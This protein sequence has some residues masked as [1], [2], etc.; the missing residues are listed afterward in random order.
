MEDLINDRQDDV[1]L[2]AKYCD[3]NPEFENGNNLDFLKKNILVIGTKDNT[4]F[5]WFVEKNEDYINDDFLLKCLLITYR[6]KS[7]EM[8]LNQKKIIEHV[9]SIKEKLNESKLPVYEKFVYMMICISIKKRNLI[10]FVEKP[11]KL[12]IETK[13]EKEFKE[14]VKKMSTTMKW[15]RSPRFKSWKINKSVS[16]FIRVRQ[17]KTEFNYSIFM[18]FL[19]DTFVY[20]FIKFLILNKNIVD[21]HKLSEN[22]DVK[23]IKYLLRRRLHRVGQVRLLDSFFD[24][25]EEE[26]KTVLGHINKRIN[27]F[28]Q[29]D[30]FIRTH[31]KYCNSKE[32]SKS[33]RNMPKKR[34]IISDDHNPKRAKLNS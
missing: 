11:K 18:G 24:M 10:K 32:K 8:C 28:F 29:N 25:Y 5:I 7:V 15:K 6:S 20:K 19:K 27:S 16:N 14:R 31:E 4:N 17:L 1:T 26:I 34:K 13:Q 3:E 30:F 12:P 22:Y 21:E 9:A 23:H 33:K 2:Y